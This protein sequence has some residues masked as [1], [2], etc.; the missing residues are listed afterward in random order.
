MPTM[1]IA[2]WMVIMMI[3]YIAV[4]RDKYELPIAIADTIREL[5]KITGTD[6]RTIRSAI[7]H[8]KSGRRKTSI[9]QEVQIESG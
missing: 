8:V 6:E 5:S 4:M 3:V 2:E 1:S 7:S 9:Y